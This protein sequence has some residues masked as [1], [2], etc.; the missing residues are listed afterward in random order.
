M[1]GI[2]GREEK[3]LN[4]RAEICARFGWG[5]KRFA[6]LVE[7]GLPVRF[8]GYSYIGHVD[9][10]ERFIREKPSGGPA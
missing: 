4:S 9:E 5:R 1:I 3:V 10:I 2:G 6:R 7:I 8:D